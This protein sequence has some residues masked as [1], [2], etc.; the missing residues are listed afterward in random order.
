MENYKTALAIATTVL[1]WGAA[2]VG[3]RAGLTDFSPGP[4]ALLRYLIASM[5]MVPIYFSIEPKNRKKLQ[6]KHLPAIII[7]GLLGIGIYNITLNIGE[8]TVSAGV[9]GFIVSQIPVV[10]IILATLVLKE[11]M[12]KLAW[13]GLSISV[14]GIVIIAMSER[15][16]GGFNNGIWMLIIATVCAGIYSGL[17]KLICC[18]YHSLQL[19]SW[20]IWAGTL[21]MLGYFHPMVHELFQASWV[22]ISWVIFLGIFPGAI[23]YTCWTYA[24]KHSAA[25]KTASFLFCMPI[26]A[27]L[28]GWL[29]LGEV[30][31]LFSLIGGCIAI[32]G[33]MMIKV[34]VN[35]TK[36]NNA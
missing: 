11:R 10:A 36:P 7:F 30:P 31:S 17:Q 33:A 34:R 16:L 19:V 5:A 6:V 22:G 23:A 24:L 9:A 3:I 21:S 25:C 18:H 15:T 20:F 29:L 1:L 13:L 8:L 14:L 26:V 12:T 32:A 28:L 2:F 35:T 4:L 27:T